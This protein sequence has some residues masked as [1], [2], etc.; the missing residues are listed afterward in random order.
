MKDVYL[1]A[2]FDELVDRFNE[3]DDMAIEDVEYEMSSK[4][5]EFLDQGFCPTTIAKM[6]SIKD[7]MD[8]VDT[9]L[10]A[11]AVL[12]AG[13]ILSNMNRIAIREYW[14]ELRKLG[15]SAEK[16]AEEVYD[17][18]EFYKEIPFFMEKGVEAKTILEL[19]TETM[20]VL[21]GSSLYDNLL[22]LKNYGLDDNTISAWVKNLVETGEDVCDILDD[23]LDEPK[24]W[25]NIGV[26]AE[27][28]IETYFDW[29]EVYNLSYLPDII[30]RDM[31]MERCKIE[32]IS[33][34]YRDGLEGFIEDFT[35]AGGDVDDIVRKIVD[36]N[37]FSNMNAD[38]VD[39]YKEVLVCEYG[40][41]SDLVKK[42]PD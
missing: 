7:V 24:K 16:L 12:D 35:D 38:D 14:D 36:E 32:D 41:A 1:Q 13:N 28:Y 20:S 21:G 3:G 11:G 8:N 6:M 5:K 15:I 30:T 22:S 23:I 39:Y 31:V 18:S 9:L 34:T 42:I 25:A 33:E 26:K 10:K 2:S 37:A 40:A 17:D 19:V 29:Y 4:W 27:D